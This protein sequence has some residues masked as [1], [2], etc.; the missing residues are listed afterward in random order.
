[1]TGKTIST[2][3]FST[4]TI[5]VNGYV[6]PL[7]IT[8][9]GTI[10]P[11]AYSATGIY[12]P[13]QAKVATIANSGV[14]EGGAAYQYYK[15][16]NAI[17]LN[18]AATVTNAGFVFGGGSGY[19]RN[20]GSIGGA[21]ILANAAVT[22]I[23]TYEILG[24][25]GENSYFH[26]GAG[27]SGVS[28]TSG[29]KLTNAYLIVGGDGGNGNSTVVTGVG[30][31]GVIT[32]AEAT[33]SNS[34]LIE[35][36]N[37]GVSDSAS[38]GYLGGAGIALNT[39]SSFTNTGTVAGGT[40]G[41][42][43]GV[44]NY[45]GEGG[46]GVD[47]YGA[48]ATNTGLILGGAGGEGS[49]YGGVGRTAAYVSDYGAFT[50]HGRVIGGAGGQGRAGGFG[51]AIESYS[52]A[53]NTGQVTGGR[54]GDLNSEVATGGNGGTGVILGGG[55]LSNTGTITGGYGGHG[56][57]YNGATSF[58][59]SIGGGAGGVGLIIDPAKYADTAT[60]VNY[61]VIQGGAGGAL[62]G[63]SGVAGNGGAGV[64]LYLPSSFTNHGTIIGGTG[65][66]SG[67]NADYYGY[68]GVGGAGVFVYAGGHV[69]NTGTIIGG[70][71]GANVG[72][73]TIGGAGVY[74]KNG[75]VFTNSGKVIGG[76][77]GHTQG[78][79]AQGDAVLFGGTIGGTLISAPGAVFDGY[80][81]GSYLPGN[82]LD[83]TGSSAV[84]LAGFGT[85]I[86][87]FTN[88]SFATGAVRT[89]EG[90]AQ[91]FETETIA[92][93]AP[94][95]SIVLDGFTAT[96]ADTTFD[97]GYIIL[98]D[99]TDNL[100]TEF[101]FER[102]LAKDLIVSASGGKTTF[103]APVGTVASTIG[104]GAGQ[105]ILSGGTATKTTVKT[106]GLEGILKGGT[107]AGATLAGGDL[108][109]EVGAK[110]TAGVSFTTVKGGELILESA[111]MPTATI[112]GFAAGD[113]I[114]LN[115]IVY[116]TNDSVTV[117]KAGVVSIVT[118][119]T[120]YSLNIAGATVGE[121]DFH[122]RAGSLLTKS[123]QAKAV[124]DF[125]R[126]QTTATNLMHR[127]TVIGP[128]IA[129]AM[130]DQ[131]AVPATTIAAASLLG[132]AETLRSTLARNQHITIPQHPA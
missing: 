125:L 106:G 126:P 75:G 58:V 54:G 50:N 110:L 39:G 130:R 48:T 1:M 90:S 122:F 18:S 102:N 63:A 51:I 45:G 112:T 108:I 113:T 56:G 61:K 115:G 96:V 64:E 19:D 92:G 124:M 85:Q 8:S 5:G 98:Y 80:V 65:G 79:G 34:L 84:A 4:V 10:D 43:Y 66:Y 49:Y 44:A 6:S 42:G 26:P 47:L 70:T 37:G 97:D 9:K 36:G 69:T 100:G 55:K 120:T 132:A 28:L 29:G 87:G 33:V 67:Q 77:G 53:T 25:T 22:I 86:Y 107:A 128:A 93:F 118:P 114:A 41:G 119:G 31:A 83:V 72:T 123:T 129:P 117:A 60:A 2:S 11:A 127:E 3:L 131:P 89:I 17:D 91:G 7:S 27:G 59:S 57:N 94:R 68:G 46:R 71:G 30:G 32:G 95:D 109:L 76:T 103:T 99:T 62:S 16:G 121:T 38:S 74:L 24:G 116:N 73:G 104:T 105:F 20:F 12:L 15:G 88:I 82:L 78:Q 13:N 35:G 14:V 52:T 81:N 111:T 23:N 21:G 101:A 40:G